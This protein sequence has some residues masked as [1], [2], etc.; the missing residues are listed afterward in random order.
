MKLLVTIFYLLLG[1]STLSGQNVQLEDYG[2]SQIPFN[3]ENDTVDI[4]LLS[5]GTKCDT[6]K[7]PLFLFV[8]GS[9]PKPI[10]F[11]DKNGAQLSPVF[12]FDVY[13]YFEDYHFII[14]GKPGIP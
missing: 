14:I 2:Y 7:K 12:P 13:K 1:L 3:Y 6:I 8:Q 5:A 10:F 4:I 11:I 9:L